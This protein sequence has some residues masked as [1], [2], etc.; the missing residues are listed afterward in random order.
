V[1]AARGA[2]FG[3]YEILEAIGRGGMGEVYRAKDS[4]LKRE[5]AIKILPPHALSHRGRRQRFER[6]AQAVAALSHPHICALFDIGSQDDTEYLVMEHLAGETLERRLARGPLPLEQAVR[7]AI[8]I[9]D[10][11]DHA[12][13]HGIVHRDLKPANIMLTE[14]G[15]KLLDF[16]LAKSTAREAVQLGVDHRGGLPETET[17]TTEG[18]ILGT[19]Q[20]LAPEQIEGKE[21]DARADL[22]AF[23]AIVYEMATGRKAFTGGSHASLMAAI[24]TADAAPMAT[25]APATPPVLERLVKKCLAKDR[26]ARWQTARDL[27]DE[28]KWIAESGISP[29][30]PRHRSGLRI[31]WLA[32]AAVA[33]AIA[34]VATFGPGF[35]SS[36]SAPREEP[37][38]RFVVPA[39]ENSTFS[40][41]S[42]HLALSPDG[43]SL[44][45]SATSPTG[46][47]TLWIRALDSPVARQLPGTEG[48]L[49]PFWSPDSRW[50]AFLPSTV[51]RQSA[52]AAGQALKKIDSAGGLPASLVDVPGAYVATWN[53]N[54][55]IIFMH[56]PN[57]SGSLY[58]TSAGG[59]APEPVTT[60]DVARGETAHVW[61]YFLPDGR[62]F[63]Y[64]ARSTQPEHNGVLHVGS[65]DT[66]AR[67]RLFGVDSH[68]EYAHGFLLYMRRGSP[69]GSRLIGGTLLAQPFDVAS[70]RV[71]GEAV[72]VAGPVDASTDFGRGAFTVSQTGV[73]A[74]RPVAE[75]QLTWYDRDGTPRQSIGSGANP[76]LSPDGQ[77]L[78]VARSDPETG[79]SSIWLMD[80][81]GGNASRL[82][83]GASLHDMPL[84][85]PDGGR[86][87]FKT[88]RG[89]G[90]AIYQKA[91]NG[92]GPE[93]A[94]LPQPEP[95]DPAIQPLS[96]I[97]DGRSLIYGRY[98]AT[99]NLD[100]A[101]LPLFG[102]RRPV[103]LFQEEFG[104]VMG[105]TSPDGRWI[106]YVST[107]TGKTE[108]YVQS[109]PSGD[110]KRKISVDGGIEP[111]WRRDG[112]EIFY[113]AADGS[114]MAVATTAGA[115]LD[116]GRPSRLFQ[117][118][119][120]PISTPNT[121]RNQY[122]VSADG[123]R[124]LVREPPEGRPM[125]PITVVVNWTAAL[126]K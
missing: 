41:S 71:A 11:L 83:S 70:R 77:R 115:A 7:R 92:V 26:E 102:D 51:K 10:A 50:L 39:P 13:R 76:A 118:K 59:R 1:T 64:Y 82:T 8:E 94:L 36:R 40:D 99:T 68:V 55:D 15:A 22:F 6:E 42:A 24:L 75:M 86:I 107:E 111:V 48:G 37:L 116:A 19:L 67:D 74:Y 101:T 57:K 113:L 25:L 62:H 89:Q 63:L 119:M 72:R 93:E 84:W 17:L 54:G 47:R 30:V 80:V 126:N 45:F 124:F 106:A 98:G 91:A 9:A 81:S 49:L 53:A 23:G 103:P 29:A 58:L 96:W 65:L 123:Q 3:P 61:P 125:L 20:Y 121:T 87:V 12:H 69:V 32:L 73:L 46:D 5:V 114:L 44:A 88:D 38:F 79:A 35:I 60:L 90:P 108:V 112:K 85:S 4:R 105:S 95:S 27:L 97:G 34:I 14:T 100:L 110:G 104:E 122:V 52:P 66:K 56:G 43:R 120:S 109:F 16:G 33:G 21:A 2:R 78:A 18:T 31:A 117:T 28:L